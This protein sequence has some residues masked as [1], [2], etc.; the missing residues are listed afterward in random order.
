MANT[1]SLEGFGGGG[2]N[3]N[4]KVV[5]GLSRPTNPNENT[6][7]VSTDVKIPSYA[8]A[9]SAPTAPVAGMVWIKTGA[10]SGVAFNA[11]KK[12]EVVVYPSACYQYIDS[13]WVSKKAT[14]YQ[15]GE[16]K[17][18]AVYLFNAGDE[19]V[20]VTGGWVA[21]AVPS[22]SNAAGDFASEEPTMVTKD[23]TLTIT[24]KST[25]GIV[26][27][28]NKVDLTPYRSLKFDGTIK[29][30]TD[31]ETSAIAYTGVY[32]WTS[33]EKYWPTTHVAASLTAG[34]KETL[35][36]EQVLDISALSGEYYVGFGVINSTS[37]IDVKQL[38]TEG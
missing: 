17:E 8:L 32:V 7:W 12:N 25:S 5:G 20:D 35:E 18:W 27:T 19:C 28:A 30:R 2:A 21:K 3:L 34:A 26:H 4:F 36:G 38:W 23:G 9:A 37:G 33:V 11:I 15:N 22:G 31:T 14:T 13:I 10:A 24:V 6:I 1:V 29:G 16:W